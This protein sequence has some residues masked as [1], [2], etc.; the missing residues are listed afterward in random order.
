MFYC[1]QTATN[2]NN[3]NNKREYPMNDQ[4]RQLLLTKLNKIS[5]RVIDSQTISGAT[6]LDLIEMTSFIKQTKQIE[7]H[8]QTELPEKK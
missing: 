7:D 3:N 6:K 2:K 4:L 8:L 1:E 5:Q